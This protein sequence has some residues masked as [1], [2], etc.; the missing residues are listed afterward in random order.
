MPPDNYNWQWDNITCGNSSGTGWAT[1]A[2]CYS[3]NETVTDYENTLQGA[4]TEKQT[5]KVSAY[6]FHC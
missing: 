2:D 3:D 1:D 6:C 4:E 5:S